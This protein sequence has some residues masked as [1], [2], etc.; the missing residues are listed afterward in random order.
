MPLDSI[1]YYF[2]TLNTNRATHTQKKRSEN[3]Q[4]NTWLSLCLAEATMMTLIFITVVWPSQIDNKEENDK[5]RQIRA[6]RIIKIVFGMRA[7]VFSSNTYRNFEFERDISAEIWNGDNLH[8]K[9]IA[10][11]AET[12]KLELTKSCGKSVLPVS[13]LD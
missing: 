13:K 4:R 9:L 1:L 11:V 6:S 2:H 10:W 8:S 5:I 3:T 7:T 12:G